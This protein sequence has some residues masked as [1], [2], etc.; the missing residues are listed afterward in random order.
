M[1]IAS[2][3]TSG[4]VLF[5]RNRILLPGN[6][7]TAVF[8]VACFFLDLNYEEELAHYSAEFFCGKL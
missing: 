5:Y 4:H 1:D 8:S 7:L 3:C 2:Y 6:D